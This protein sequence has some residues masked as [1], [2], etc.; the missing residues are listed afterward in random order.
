MGYY[1]GYGNGICVKPNLTLGAAII[2][3]FLAADSLRLFIFDMQ[4]YAAFNGGK[5][6]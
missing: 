4:D 5:H 2:E 6:D 3:Q 1:L